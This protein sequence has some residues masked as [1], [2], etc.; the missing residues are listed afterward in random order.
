MPN[1]NQTLPTKPL[2]QLDQD[3]KAN[4]TEI[5]QLQIQ[6][7]EELAAIKSRTQLTCETAAVDLQ[8]LQVSCALGCIY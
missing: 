7:N 2:K 4:V 3:W 8:K 1:E 6:C 5:T